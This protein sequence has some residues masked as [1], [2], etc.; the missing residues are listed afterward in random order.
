MKYDVH[1]NIGWYKG[2]L[3]CSLAWNCKGNFI[4]HYRSMHGHTCLWNK[5]ASTLCSWD[6]SLCCSS[7]LNKLTVILQSVIFHHFLFVD[8][9]LRINESTSSFPV[10]FLP[11]SIICWLV[12]LYLFSHVQD[13]V[14]NGIFSV[15]FILTLHSI[16]GARNVSLCYQVP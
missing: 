10:A 2:F 15:L 3:G 9:L 1:Q 16:S 11:I 8:L 4:R 5:S 7:R 13:P 14:N 6:T 12:P